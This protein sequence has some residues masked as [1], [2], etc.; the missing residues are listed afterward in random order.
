MTF[1][2]KLF[3]NLLSIKNH[4]SCKWG[5]LALHRHEEIFKKIFLSEFAGQILKK[6]SQKCSLVDFFKKCL[7]NFDLSRNKALVNGGYLR[8]YGHEELHKILLWIAG[9]TE[10]ILQRCSWVTLLKI[11]SRHFTS[12]GIIALVYGGYLHYKDKEKFLE[13]LLWNRDRILK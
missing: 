1:F 5:L 3:V 8:Y 13:I 10:I 7:R 11:C 6:N 4:E 9:Q 12:L 2:K